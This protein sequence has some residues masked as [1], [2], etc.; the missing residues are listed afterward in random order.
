MATTNDYCCVCN[1]S[2]AKY[3]CSEC[4]FIYCG[5]TCQSIDWHVHKKLF[6][7]S[8]YREG[9]GAVLPQYIPSS[10]ESIV[11]KA[12]KD[13]DR[14][15]GDVIRVVLAYIETLKQEL[16]NWMASNPEDAVARQEYAYIK[17]LYEPQTE[18]TESRGYMSCIDAFYEAIHQFFVIHPEMINIHKNLYSNLNELKKFH[19]ENPAVFDEAEKVIPSQLTTSPVDTVIEIS[20]PQFPVNSLLTGSKIRQTSLI[21]ALI[22]ALQPTPQYPGAREYRPIPLKGQNLSKYAGSGMEILGYIAVSLPKIAFSDV[23]VMTDVLTPLASNT[24]QVS[25]LFGVLLSWDHR[26]MSVDTFAKEAG[27]TSYASL[28]YNY[29]MNKV[30]SYSKNIPL[31]KEIFDELKGGTVRAPVLVAHLID[32]LME[33]YN[34]Y[35]SKKQEHLVKILDNISEAFKGAGEPGMTWR[36]LVARVKETV[37]KRK[38]IKEGGARIA[39][40]EILVPGRKRTS[41]TEDEGEFADKLKKYMESEKKVP[42]LN[43]GQ[44]GNWH[45][46][47]I[48]ALD[49]GGIKGAATIRMLLGIFSTKHAMIIDGESRNMDTIVCEG[50]YYAP[51]QVFDLVCGTSTGSFIAYWIA[52]MRKPL[53]ELLDMYKVLST[54]VF[55]NMYKVKNWIPKMDK[56]MTKWKATP[57]RRA[58]MH[59]TM[60]HNITA[61]QINTFDATNIMSAD[62]AMQ[63][64]NRMLEE[65]PRLCDEKSV[66]NLLPREDANRIPYFFCT[67]LDAQSSIQKFYLFTNYTSLEEG[68]PDPNDT[69]IRTNHLHGWAALRASSA[70][71][72]FFH[73]LKI[74]TDDATF[75]V[76]HNHR[77]FSSLKDCVFTDGGVGA[78]NPTYF[79]VM[80]LARLVGAYNIGHVLSVGTGIDPEVKNDRLRNIAEGKVVAGYLWGFNWLMSEFAKYEPLTTFEILDVLT[81]SATSTS[82]AIGITN[83]ISS[84][85][86][87]MSASRLDTQYAK[88]MEMDEPESLDEIID[89]AARRTVYSEK[90]SSD[91][92]YI[93]KRLCQTTAEAWISKGEKPESMQL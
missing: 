19:Q 70:A 16:E 84:I 44:L 10:F 64:E 60:G 26:T 28:V 30:Q 69:I 20:N 39:E 92:K 93:Q 47:N 25:I 80:E 71:P 49:G 88:K 40:E 13:K 17:R 61:A 21:R 2:G 57:L 32:V 77:N 87:M 11:N 9:V 14:E 62:A 50:N 72:T 36:S 31:L 86:P 66:A 37:A 45:P 7:G 51:H 12:F 63:A 38:E 81:I 41:L 58:L 42:Y 4:G 1:R 73:P 78:N 56:I 22:D 89:T 91:I 82:S 43:V 54:C 5:E 75:C 15:P 90:G 68:T 83:T 52:V 23:I 3:K 18:V 67:S 24:R 8:K 76:T 33:C 29:L 35:S 6:C 65:A 53:T 55:N 27:A 79:G 34:L 46:S 48:L 74:D 59:M 85:L